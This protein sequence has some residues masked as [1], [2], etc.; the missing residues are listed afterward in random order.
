L[1][2]QTHTTTQGTTTKGASAPHEDAQMRIGDVARL[3]GTTPRTIRYYEEIGLLPGTRERSAGVH[4]TYTAG[5]V[6]RLREI[7]SLR[8]LLGVSLEELKELISA[9]EA[10]AALKAEYK[11]EDLSPARRREVLAESLTHIERQLALV[12]R[13]VRELSGLRDDLLDRAARI[14]ALLG[15][16]TDKAGTGTRAAKAKRTAHA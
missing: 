12:E 14:R 8:Q 1:S 5:D 4:R 16:P 2:S 3:V 10:R 9:Q 13:R 7:M 15:D 6:E 11:R